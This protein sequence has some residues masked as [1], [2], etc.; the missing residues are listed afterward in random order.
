MHRLALAWLLV[1]G[2]GAREQPC[3][4]WDLDGDRVVRIAVLG[5]SNSFILFPHAW[6]LALRRH[7][8]AKEPGRWEVRSYARPHARI[9]EYPANPLVSASH[10][11]QQAEAHD[12][13]P[14]LVVLAFGTNDHRSHRAAAEILGAYRAAARRLGAGARVRIA[15]T[16][17]CWDDDCDP[18]AIAES[19]RMLRA[20]WPAEEL[21]DFDSWVVR[22]D[23]LPDRVHFGAEGHR[24]RLAAVLDV[25]F[26]HAPAT[27]DASA[28][29]AR[30]PRLSPP[31]PPS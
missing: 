6:T 15:T 23:L 29:P 18:A 12:P 11:I 3:D 2:C 25:L 28:P 10:Q 26:R 31:P 16:P 20:A 24:K 21:I 7:L 22:G 17:A 30:R 4:A 8:D 5:D 1:T 13:P 9:T 27:R 19:N 14:E